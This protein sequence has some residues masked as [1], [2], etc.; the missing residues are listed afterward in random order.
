MKSSSRDANIRA[1]YAEIHSPFGHDG[2][3][4]ENAISSNALMETVYA[5]K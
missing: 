1:R 3:L 2:F 5:Q 4:V